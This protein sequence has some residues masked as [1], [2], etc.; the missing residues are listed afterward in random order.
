MKYVY[1]LKC[2][3]T[4]YYTGWITDVQRRL[5][6]HNAAKASKYTRSRLPVELVY[7]EVVNTKSEALRREAA[8]KKLRRRQKADLISLCDLQEQQ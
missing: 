3:D 8:I 4:S 2:A 6:Q 7:V 5:T 1:I